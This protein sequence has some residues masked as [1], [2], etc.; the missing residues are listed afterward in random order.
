MVDT[1]SAAPAPVNPAHRDV[2][3]QPCDECQAVAG[4]PC[5]EPYCPASLGVEFMTLADPGVLDS[6]TCVPGCDNRADLDGFVM[7]RAD[8]TPDDSP[9]WR[10][11]GEL[12]GCA[13]CGRVVSQRGVLDDGESLQVLDH[14]DVIPAL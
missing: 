11:D 3:A 14:L 8:G 1:A 7:V 6:L 13:G 5:V 12:L 4:T 9:A 2:A 10:R